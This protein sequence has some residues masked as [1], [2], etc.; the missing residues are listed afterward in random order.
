MKPRGPS[1]YDRLG[2]MDVIGDIVV[3]L[4]EV[5]LPQSPLAPRFTGVERSRLEDGLA[6]WLCELAD[7]PCRYPGRSLREL[8]AGMGITEAE[9]EAFLAALEHSLVRMRVAPDVRADVLTIVRGE[10]DSI[11][12]PP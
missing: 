2:R 4:V 5:E 7:G 6:R 12:Q 10:H 3:D 9:F 11:V 8:H 1:L